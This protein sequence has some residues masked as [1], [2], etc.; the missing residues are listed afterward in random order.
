MKTQNNFS[1]LIDATSESTFLHLINKNKIIDHFNKQNN[2][3]LS[4][5]L[6]KYIDDFL[7][8]NK[9]SFSDLNKIYLIYGPGKFSAMRI[10]LIV[11]QTIC[12]VYGTELYVANKFDYYASGDCICIINS[13]GNKYF[14]AKY[15]NNMMHGDPKL[16]SKQEMDE[17][18]KNNNDLI[19]YENNIFND[20]SKLDKFSLVNDE[21]E[22]EYYKKPC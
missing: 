5:S 14:V 1:I 8:K 19:I 6:I 9:V 21:F 15:I 22:L 3:D 17:I 11:S 4:F 10:A 20:I 13:D 2:K 7:K 16:V 18:L 12:F